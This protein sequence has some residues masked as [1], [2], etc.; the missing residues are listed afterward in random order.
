MSA[1]RT[2]PVDNQNNTPPKF[3]GNP[4]SEGQE[5]QAAGAARGGATT[6]GES[7]SPDTQET[8]KDAPAAG[9]AGGKYSAGHVAC[10]ALA[11]AAGGWVLG[12]ALVTGYLAYRHYYDK[13]NSQETNAQD[14]GRDAGTGPERNNSPAPA[15]T[16]AIPAGMRSGGNAQSGPET[17][18]P[19]MSKEK[20]AEQ[21]RQQNA[22][23]VPG[24]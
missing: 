12:G 8:E 18:P 17:P 1:E 10:A 23:H 5:P 19:F 6:P 20:I 22:G 15:Q 13:D 14:A 9:P 24:G 21:Q 16:P 3:I 4:T 2:Q 7:R 11:V